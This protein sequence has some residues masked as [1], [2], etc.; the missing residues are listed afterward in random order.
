MDQK[1]RHRIYESGYLAVNDKSRWEIVISDQGTG[2]SRDDLSHM[3]RIGGSV[4]NQKRQSVIRTMPEWMKPSGAFGIGFQSAFMVSPEVSLDT[5]SIYTNEIL[6]VTM[7]SPTGPKEGLVLVEAMPADVARDYGTVVRLVI[8]TESYPTRYST[9]DPRD[10]I[11]TAFIQSV[12]PILDDKF[13]Y[14][15][16]QLADEITK[17][18]E[19][20]LIPIHGEM[21]TLDST[22]TVGSTSPA[23]EP[24]RTMGAW[25]FL[26]VSDD[27]LWIRFKPASSG[28][29]PHAFE[30]FYRGQPFEYKRYIPYSYIGIDLMSRKAGAWL[31]ASRDKIASEADSSLYSLALQAIELQVERELAHATPSSPIAVELRP[32]YSRFLEI[33]ALNFG[34]RW[35]D[36]ASRLN[37]AWLDLTFDKR[38]ETFRIFFNGAGGVVAAPLHFGPEDATETDYVVDSSGDDLMMRLLLRSWVTYEGGTVGVI[39]P[40]PIN[41]QI[42]LARLPGGR[43]N[44]METATLNDKRFRTRYNLSRSEQPAYTPEA[45]A[46]RLISRVGLGLHN[47]R[48]LLNADDCW[49]GLWLKVP[50]SLRASPLFIVADPKPKFVVLPFLF[51]GHAKTVDSN[52]THLDRLSSWS[53][54][55]VEQPSSFSEIRKLYEELVAYIDDEIMGRSAYNKLWRKARGFD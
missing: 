18:S 6:R 55:R 43:D 19:R 4:R 8:E 27:V 32:F 9:G 29:H 13:H 54:S 35:S 39:E 5:K 37:R 41:E 42:E 3:L 15:A 17:F 31:S 36:L 2:I 7:F 30:T 22:L 48:F 40:K 12:D 44:P 28:F 51:R 25:S 38:T 14:E 20:S 34:G 33:M 49:R 23:F 26:A 11:A 10:T 53:L 24:D 46:A 21:I 16:A 1:M 47:Q 45:L 50:F 52:S